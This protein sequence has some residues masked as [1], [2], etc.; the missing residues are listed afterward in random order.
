MTSHPK[1]SYEIVDH[2]NVKTLHITNAKRFWEKSN[3]LVVQVD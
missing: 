1:D 2:G 3:F